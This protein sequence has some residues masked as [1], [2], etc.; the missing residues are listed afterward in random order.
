MASRFAPPARLVALT[1]LTVAGVVNYLDRGAVALAVEPIRHD[2]GLS[3]GE[4][5]LVLASFAW[6]Y[7]L[8]QIP[9]GVLVDRFGPRP[10]LAVGLCIWSAAQAACAGAAGIGSFVAARLALGLGESPLYL[11]GTKV[12]TAWWDERHRAVPIGIF[13]A[14]SALGPAIA[15]PVLATLIAAF[16]WRAAFV[17]LAGLGLAV[18]IAWTVLYRD[19]P[20]GDAPPGRD[21]PS[22]APAMSPGASWHVLL[23][24]PVGWSLAAGFFGIIYLTWLY[25]S[26]WP[27]YLASE[28]HLST[29]EIGLWAAVP[30][31]CGFLGALCGGVVSSVLARRGVPPVASCTRPL[32]VALAVAALATLLLA[33][34]HAAAPAI[35]L[36]CVA[37]FAANLASSCGWAAASVAVERSAVATLQG[38]QNV[39]GSLGGSIAPLLS[40]VLIQWSGSFSDALITGAAIAAASAAVYAF[41]L[42]PRRA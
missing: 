13:N 16:G 5:G 38:I 3:R 8:A 40:G 6:S 9:A 32:V 19:P 25:S 10:L 14:S 35:G 11:A 21:A 15:P 28:L 7:G 36:A 24:T 1:L 26:W 42:R 12:C 39:G 34:A 4:I 33:Y 27:D 41:G 37:L 31:F 18:A 23:R 22:A 17:V 30:Q 20:D 29:T 2:L